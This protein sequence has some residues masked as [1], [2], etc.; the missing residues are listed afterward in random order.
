M[1]TLCYGIDDLPPV[2]ADVRE[3]LR[4]RWEEVGL[5]PLLNEL[6]RVDPDY[7]A[8]VDRHN[9]RRV[10]RALEVFYSSGTLFSVFQG[11]Q[12]AAHRPFRVLTI[13]LTL[14]RD[15]LYERIERRVDQMIAVGLVEEARSLYPWRQQ[16]ALRTVG[17][18]ELFSS[19]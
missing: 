8:E 15:V 18:Q 13:G 6:A 17:Y 4:K 2:S 12:P 9:H 10:M 19:V 16:Q 3:R 14:P 7:Y 1:K 5:A 11:R